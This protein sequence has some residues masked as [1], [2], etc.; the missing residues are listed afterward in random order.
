M[1]R[2]DWGGQRA[3]GLVRDGG[4]Q[5]TQPLP[6]STRAKAVRI[7][8]AWSSVTWRLEVLLDGGEV[9][10]LR[11]L[12]RRRARVGDPRERR[13]GGRARDLAHDQPGL[14]IRATSRVAPPRD[15]VS[16]SASSDIRVGSV[17]ELGE[18]LEP[19]GRQPGLALHAAADAVDEAGVHL[20]KAEEREPLGVFPR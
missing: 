17:L 11:A 15:S 20:Q 3:G 4:A 12:Q 9:D 2:T 8:A 14:S 10:G 7:A 18:H 13:R 5:R 1:S 19:G 6:T 16:D